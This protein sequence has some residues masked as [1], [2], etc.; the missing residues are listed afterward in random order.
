MIAGVEQENQ[1]CPSSKDLKS[2]SAKQILR[3]IA[4]HP[5]EARKEWLSACF[6][7]FATAIRMTRTPFWQFGFSGGCRAGMNGLFFFNEFFK[8]HGLKPNARNGGPSHSDSVGEK[9]KQADGAIPYGFIG[10]RGD[11]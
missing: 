3:A 5:D 4:A 10:V 9:L 11:P 2:A 8:V 1:T 7:F 6:Q